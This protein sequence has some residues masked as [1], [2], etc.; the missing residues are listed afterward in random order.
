M[1]CPVPFF[2]EVGPIAKQNTGKRSNESIR[3]VGLAWNVRGLNGNEEELD[4]I[5]KKQKTNFAAICDGSI[6]FSNFP[7][8]NFRFE[9]R[10]ESWRHATRRL[11]PKTLPTSKLCICARN[12]IKR[13]KRKKREP[14]F[15][16]FHSP[17]LN[18]YIDLRNI[19]NT[20][21]IQKEKKKVRAYGSL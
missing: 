12:Q 21:N 6:P 17:I 4:Y 16:P 11:G 5:F 9:N 13:K 8:S 2:R 7:F 20:L 10:G 14:E 19:R 3:V 1:F 15:L 18:T